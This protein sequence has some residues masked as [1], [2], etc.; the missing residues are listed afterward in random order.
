MSLLFKGATVFNQNLSKWCVTNIT[1]EP[2]SF[3]KDSLL[4]EL[5]KPVWG[6]CPD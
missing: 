4:S 5:N 6:T 2:D 1:S 3:S